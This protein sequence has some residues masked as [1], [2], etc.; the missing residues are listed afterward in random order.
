[1]ANWSRPAPGPRRHGPTDR[2]EGAPAPSTDRREGA[3]APSRL[4]IGNYSCT[5]LRMWKIFGALL[6]LAPPLLAQERP[7]AYEAMRTVGQRDREYVNHILSVTGT[8]GTPQP[9]TWTILIDDPKARGGVREF[10]VGEGRILSERTPLR[11]SV[12]GSLG[13]V[14][15][16]AKLN[17]DSSGAYALAQQTAAASHVAL[18]SA[19]YAL[20]MD[21]RGNPI[22]KITVLRQDGEAAGSIFIGANHGTVTRTEGL[23]AGTNGNQV[24][25]DQETENPDREPA[26]EADN[27]DNSDNDE[28]NVVERRIKHTFYKVR[29]DVKRTFYKVRR[30]FVDFFRDH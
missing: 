14:I 1:M 18:G 5:I 9:A 26:D 28:G 19:D 17:L 7:T 8:N 27:E 13:P 12:E 6:L 3:P 16:T 23:F 21:D 24:A 2:R 22:W 20:R 11:S 29:D 25:M 30:S 10:E 4:A 15:D